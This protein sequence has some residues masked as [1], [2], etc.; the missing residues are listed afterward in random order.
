MQLAYREIK[1]DEKPGI[2]IL[3]L[4]FVRW[5]ARRRLARQMAAKARAA[6]AARSATSKACTRI[7]DAQKQAFEAHQV[8]MRRERPPRSLTEHIQ[9]VREEYDNLV[10]G[11]IVGPHPVDVFRVF[12][13]GKTPLEEAIGYLELAKTLPLPPKLRFDSAPAYVNDG[14]G[15][16]DLSRL[17]HSPTPAKYDYDLP[18][19]INEPARERLPGAPSPDERNLVRYGTFPGAWPQHEAYIAHSNITRDTHAGVTEDK[20]EPNRVDG[21]PGASRGGKRS[22]VETPEG[23]REKYARTR[24][25]CPGAPRK[26]DRTIRPW[27]SDTALPVREGKVRARAR[28]AV[29]PDGDDEIFG[30]RG[31]SNEAFPKSKRARHAQL[32]RMDASVTGE[33]DERAQVS[34]RSDRVGHP[35]DPLRERDRTM[36][37]SAHKHSDRVGVTNDSE[38]IRRRRCSISSAAAT[39]GSIEDGREDTEREA[40]YYGRSERSTFVVRGD[41]TD[42]EE[43]G[44]KRPASVS[45]TN[46]TRGSPQ[47]SAAGTARHVVP[48]GSATVRQPSRQ[49]IPN[50]VSAEIKLVP[51]RRAPVPYDINVRPGRFGSF[52]GKGEEEK[53]APADTRKRVPLESK[54]SGV[55]RGMGVDGAVGGDVAHA[56]RRALPGSRPL[57]HP[58]RTRAYGVP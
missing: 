50:V 1:A 9:F 7:I 6:A 32:S 43:H 53:P 47:S 2:Y 55:P 49:T 36:E 45:S 44:K 11:P 5:V 30:I 20:V 46:A 33:Q 15:N 40:R 26:Q 42:N 52:K 37:T 27:S 24:E 13:L 3:A 4:P 34:G 35:S 38:R 48:T 39:R 58:A 31:G 54:Y 8:A 17:P 12:D 22:A 56:Q 23:H 28:D 57:G 25:S 18:S 10:D 16:A 51:I 19:S 14:P 41:R 29:R 21:S